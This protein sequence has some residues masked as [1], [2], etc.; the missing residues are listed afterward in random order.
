[1]RSPGAGSSWPLLAASSWDPWSSA[2]WYRSASLCADHGWST[3]RSGWMGRRHRTTNLEIKQ[4]QRKTGLRLGMHTSWRTT[5]A[6]LYYISLL[7]SHSQPSC[8]IFFWSRAVAECR[9]IKTDQRCHV[10]SRCWENPYVLGWRFS[11]D[12]HL[13]F[14]NGSAQMACH[15]YLPNVFLSQGSVVEKCQL[16]NTFGTSVYLKRGMCVN[17]SGK[18]IL[19]YLPSLK[20]SFLGSGL[21]SRYH[22]SG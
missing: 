10:G 1:M 11:I 3:C 2:T 20:L 18:L 8:S 19:F 6:L 14:G 22:L 4:T 12:L 16:K 17:S 7:Q 9:K 5:I 15:C 21:A 13:D